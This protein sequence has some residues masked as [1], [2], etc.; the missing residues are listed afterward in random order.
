MKK[1]SFIAHAES[2]ANAGEPTTNDH[3][4][5]LTERGWHD[6][7]VF[8]D[9]ITEKPDI[10]LPAKYLR[11][12]QTALPLIRKFPD[13]P[14]KLI[15]LHE[16]TY[17]SPESCVNSTSAQRNPLVDRYWQQAGPDDING[18]DA[19]S[20]NQFIKRLNSCI[21][22]L[23]NMAG[24]NL[25]IFTHGHVLRA[26]WQ[27]LGDHKFTSGREQMHHFYH[28]MGILPVPNLANFQ[29]VYQK[30]KWQL[31]EPQLPTRCT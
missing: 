3:S 29:A 10:I 27:I 2:Q 7:K 31:I 13:V 4:I 26:L 11:T 15:N 5:E 23:E 20:F 19:E 18:P 16:F 22:M 6:A 28:Q 8:A 1:I 21:E 12:W 17:L 30:N 24:Q 25:V 14:V 9:A